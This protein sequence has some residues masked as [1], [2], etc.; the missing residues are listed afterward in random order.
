MAALHPPKKSGSGGIDR[1]IRCSKHPAVHRTGLEK[2]GLLPLLLTYH[3]SSAGGPDR[4]GDVPHLHSCHHPTDKVLGLS[5][6]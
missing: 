5:P 1:N 3:D 2:H 6:R 4:D